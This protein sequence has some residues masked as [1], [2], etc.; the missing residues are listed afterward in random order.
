MARTALGRPRVS[1]SSLTGR[2]TRE[3]ILVAS[4]ELFCT[5]GF[6]GTST[7]A[8]AATA[9]I[10]QASLYHYFRSKQEIL[11]ELL[12]GTV[13]PSLDTAAAL[14]ASRKSS[15][16]ARLWALCVSDVRLLSSGEQNVGALYLL[17]ELEGDFF[18]PFHKLRLDLEDCYQGLMRE[19]G[20]P[21]QEVVDSAMLVLALVENVILL[22]RRSPEAVHPGRAETIGSAALRMLGIPEVEI[23][24]ARD[25][26]VFI[27]EELFD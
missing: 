13:K 18:Q 17:P 9:G 14:A 3:D 11:L 7:H 24:R 12:L 19:C 10:R 22:R 15:P 16:V 2:G 8:I 21:E 26:G 5:R 20:I 25:D 27:L 4:A 23:D 1:G 6:A